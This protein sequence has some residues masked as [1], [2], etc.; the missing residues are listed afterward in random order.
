MADDNVIQAFQKSELP[1]QTLIIE[2]RPPGKPF[3]CQHGSLRINEHERTLH[4]AQCGQALD[5]FDFIHK[6]AMVINRA[7]QDHTHVT[8]EMRDMQDCVTALKK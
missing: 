2:P 6:S 7:W 4:C 3:F 5:P 1:E 8:R